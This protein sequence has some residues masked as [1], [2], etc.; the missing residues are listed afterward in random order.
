MNYIYNMVV[1]LWFVKLFRIYEQC[2]YKF[3]IY[4]KAFLRPNFYK[5]SYFFLY[6]EEIHLGMQKTVQSFHIFHLSFSR[7]RCNRRQ[8]CIGS[9]G[10]F[11]L[12]HT[13]KLN[14]Y[15]FSTVNWILSKFSCFK[16]LFFCF[17]FFFNFIYLFQ[18]FVLPPN[19]F[20]IQINKFNVG[21]YTII[22]A[23]AATRH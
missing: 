3:V 22:C 19:S 23:C 10:G 20:S 15:M 4:I 18:V 21:E 8:F 16:R 7:R 11:Y 12:H 2:W 14:Y 9:S 5:Y 6:F 1:L 13:L 17:S